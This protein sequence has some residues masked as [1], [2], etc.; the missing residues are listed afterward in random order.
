MTVRHLTHISPFAALLLFPVAL[1]F[2]VGLSHVALAQ[3]APP[4]APEA[5]DFASIT[6][7]LIAAWQARNY[8]LIVVLVAPGVT[9]LARRY[10]SILLPWL[11]SGAGH[12]ALVL[13]PAIFNAF[14][15]AVTASGFNGQAILTAIVAAILAAFTSYCGAA[16]PSLQQAAASR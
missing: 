8:A 10:L 11:H 15:A 1:M 3:G 16:N 7:A 13:V 12:V 9:F 6:T 4:S 5:P 14:V 2:L